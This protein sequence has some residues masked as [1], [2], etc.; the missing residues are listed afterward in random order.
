VAVSIDQQ[1]AALFDVSYGGLR[2]EL[3]QEPQSSVPASVEV[4]LPDLSM[5]VKGET[6]WQGPASP[7]G[8]WWCG[9]RVEESDLQRW[10]NAIDTLET[11][12]RT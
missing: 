2:L 12:P 3:P 11:P 6:I 7:P 4:N 5:S 10:Q 9:V 8:K 1:P